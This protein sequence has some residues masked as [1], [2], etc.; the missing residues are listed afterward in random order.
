LKKLGPRLANLKTQNKAGL[1]YSSDSYHGIAFM[2]FD[3]QAN[4]MTVLQQFYR[5]LYRLNAGVDFVF[6]D[7]QNLSEYRVL[8]VPPLYVASDQLLLRL[9]AY[10]NKGGHLVLAFKSGFTNE[11]STVRWTRMPG[12]LREAAGFSYQEFSTLKRPLPLRGDPFQAGDQNRVSIWAEM[13]VP[14]TAKVL[15]SYDHPFF[16]KYAA[17]TRN[18]FGKGTLT[19]EGTLLSDDL[20]QKV[21]FQVLG[22]AGLSGPDQKLPPTVR[23][24]H[25]TSNAGAR[26]HFYLNYSGQPQSVAYPYGNGT[27]LFTGRG[28]SSGS[29]IPLAAWDLAVVEER[30]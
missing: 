16:G 9:A 18:Q 12:P 19:Y 6:P 26:L 17:I 14:E 24:K 20:Q 15:A 7:S 3:Q 28:I 22:L 8:V 13:I 23:V 2:P 29:Q 30:R 10:V 4:Y 21:L 1:L 5:A 11:Y 25:G 27:E